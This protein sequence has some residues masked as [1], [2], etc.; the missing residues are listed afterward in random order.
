MP[1]PTPLRVLGGNTVL[2]EKDTC[3]L[4]CPLGT[5]Q[6]DEDMGHRGQCQAVGSAGHAQNGLWLPW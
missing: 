6:V 1:C 4:E 2:V 3:S 5:T